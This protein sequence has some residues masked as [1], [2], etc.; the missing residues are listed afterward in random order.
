MHRIAAEGFSEDGWRYERGRA[1]YPSEA[2]DWLVDHLRIGPNSM[3]A[4]VA[5]GTGKLTRELAGRCRL[6]AVEPV[7]QMHEVLREVTEVPVVEAVAEHLPFADA[8]FDAITIAQALHWFDRERAGNELHRLLKP[9]TRLGLI[10]NA[11]DRSHPVVD[12]LWSIMDEIESDAPWRQERARSTNAVPGFGPDNRQDFTQVVETTRQ[13]VEDRMLS[14]SYI[15]VLAPD[16][17]TE[18]LAE[19]RAVWDHHLG[20]EVESFPF[21]Y[22]VEAYWLE[23]LD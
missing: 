18:V 22:R 20:P 21:P 14:V 10:W 11:R 9:G 3:V 7:P 6:L 15:S 19:C 16:K 23:R 8:T 2:V 17:R 13:G 4:D 12:A 5:A 1:G